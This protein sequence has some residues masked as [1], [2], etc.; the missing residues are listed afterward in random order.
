[1][2]AEV[3][4]SGREWRDHDPATL[5]ALWRLAKATKG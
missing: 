5:D 1:V 4:A 2:E 3:A